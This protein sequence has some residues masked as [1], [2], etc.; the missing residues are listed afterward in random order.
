MK[1]PK[2]G[3]DLD[4]TVIEFV[5]GLIEFHNKKY[6]HAHERHH[7]TNWNIHETWGCTEEEG[8][9]R[10]VEFY[11]SEH[12]QEITAIPGAL[13]ALL[14]LSAEYDLVAI[15]A[16]D[17]IRA[18]RVLPLIERLFG[19]IFTEVHFLGHQLSKGDKCVELGVRFMVDDALHNAHSVGERGIQ[20]F[21]MN[22]PWNQGTLP[23][24]TIRVANWQEVIAHERL[25]LLS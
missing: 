9:R 17:P 16:R 13:D 6:G 22:Q 24:N 18:P 14:E 3:V 15:T 20:V 25:L 8:T 2:I 7:F 4:D 23:P 11:H 1:K 21:L 12:H 5:A 10:I 19:N